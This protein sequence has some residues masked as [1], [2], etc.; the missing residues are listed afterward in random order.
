MDCPYIPELSYSDFGT[1]LRE[2]IAGKRVPLSGSLELTFRC[3]LRC[4]HCYLDG[5]HD[6]IPGQEEL[7]T[8][9]WYDLLDQMADMGTLWLLMTGGEPFVRPDFLDIYT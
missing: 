3:N 5:V 9:E 7:T 2:R 1:R 8:E 4:K 6:G